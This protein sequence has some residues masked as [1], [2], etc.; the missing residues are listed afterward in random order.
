M[1]HFLTQRCL[2]VVVVVVVVQRGVGF[3][4]DC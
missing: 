3:F 1:D 4:E 2:V